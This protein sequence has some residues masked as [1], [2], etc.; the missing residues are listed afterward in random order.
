MNDTALFDAQARRVSAALAR[1]P[2]GE[3][4]DR[5]WE[6]YTDGVCS[7]AI[8]LAQGDIGL[9]PFR[10]EM[11]VCETDFADHLERIAASVDALREEA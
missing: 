6:G 7:L 3:E 2:D 4:L 1:I 10:Q 11:L 8:S 5:A 9:H